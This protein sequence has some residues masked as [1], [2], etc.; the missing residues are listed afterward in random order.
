MYYYAIGF[1]LS[2]YAFHAFVTLNDKALLVAER[3]L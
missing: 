3:A 1:F 2:I